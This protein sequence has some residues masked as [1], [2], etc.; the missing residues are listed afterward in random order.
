MKENSVKDPRCKKSRKEAAKLFHDKVYE[1]KND[2]II[3]IG[4]VR[5]WN[6]KQK[7]GFIERS[8]NK[9]QIFVHMKSVLFTNNSKFRSRKNM[10]AD[11]LTEGQFVQFIIDRNKRGLC[12]KNV[13]VGSRKK[14]FRV[15][16]SKFPIELIQEM[17]NIRK[18]S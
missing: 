11:C 18:K 2:A 10:W 6:K 1:K 9:E 17:K 15:V 13:I 16:K 7:F 3:E 5:F 14:G 8:L 4:F 12:A